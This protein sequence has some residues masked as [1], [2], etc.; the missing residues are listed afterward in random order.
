MQSFNSVLASLMANA[1]DS[2]GSE[3]E[4]ERLAQQ[5]FAAQVPTETPTDQ[6][7]VE[8]LPAIKIATAH[9]DNKASC[10]VCFDAF[11]LGEEGV[12]ELPCEHLYH[13]ACI[14]P[15]LAT[16][17]TCPVCRAPLPAAAAPARA[18]AVDPARAAELPAAPMNPF[19]LFEMLNTSGISIHGPGRGGG[20]HPWGSSVLRR[21]PSEG[22]EGSHFHGEEAGMFDGEGDAG[23][24][25]SDDE[26]EMVR[27]A[28]AASLAEEEE[29]QRQRSSM[30]VGQRVAAVQAPDAPGSGGG[31]ASSSESSAPRFSQRYFIP[32]EP[33]P[34]G[35]EGAFTLKLRL[36]DASTVVRRFPPGATI[37][38]VVAFIMSTDK[39]PLFATAPDGSPQLRLI[40]MGGGGAP[41]SAGSCGPFSSESWDIP[42]SASGLPK[43]AQL[44]VEG[45]S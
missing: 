14:H 1:R 40:V 22:S 2:A 27:A 8:A 12:I 7:A 23:G 15:W 30:T 3:E 35:D 38:A 21:D 29:R 13:P 26:D 9:V 4:V 25:A 36:P 42:L 16:H 33:I 39:R 34:G 20:V 24:H 5:L 18:P 10:S 43:R 17:N 19:A 45:W 37:G 32:P 44:V 28:I 11:E 41:A 31:S 6:R